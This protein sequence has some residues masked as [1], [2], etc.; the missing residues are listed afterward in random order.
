MFLSLRGYEW[1][2]CC[3]V[4]CD[5]ILHTV[6]HVSSVKNISCE[7]PRLT[8]PALPKPKFGIEYTA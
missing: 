8:T 5:E 6:A 3:A 1:V 2:P 4:M 7:S